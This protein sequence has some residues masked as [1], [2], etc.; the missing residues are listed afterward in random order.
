MSLHVTLAITCR[1]EL[2][3]LQEFS[4]KFKRNQFYIKYPA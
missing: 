2:K 4:E 1:K 3:F